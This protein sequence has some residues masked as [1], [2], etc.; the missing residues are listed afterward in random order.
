MRNLNKL[1]IALAI[2]SFSSPAQSGLAQTQDDNSRQIVLD[3]FTNARPPKTSA[4]TAGGGRTRPPS[5]RKPPTYRRV[6]KPSLASTSRAN[7]ELGITVWRLRPSK[8]NDTGA[9]LLVMENSQSS[10]WTPERIEVDTPLAVGDRVR[11]SVESPRAGFLYVVDR[12]QF[13][14]GTFGDPYL[15]FPTTRTRGGDN[16]VRPGKLIDIPAQ[17][18]NPSYF[19]LIPSPTRSDQVAEVLSFI[20]TPAPLNNLAIGDRPLKLSPADVAKWEQ[21]WSSEVE[22]FEMNGGAGRTWTPEEKA[23]GAMAGSRLLN[24]EEPTPQTVYRFARRN[25]STVLVTVPLRYGR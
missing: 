7:E 15:I 2:V 12:E 8:Q 25:R 16:R 4:S 9:R 10:Q 21:L 3:S 14:D 22:R 5:V 6:G 1:I 24:Q 19:T 23:A 11:I 17:E 18:D 13:Q 20:V